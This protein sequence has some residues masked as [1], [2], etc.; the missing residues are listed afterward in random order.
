MVWVEE[1]QAWLWEE[2]AGSRT[3]LMGWGSFTRLGLGGEGKGES[4]I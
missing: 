3:K 4:V 1:G 2:V